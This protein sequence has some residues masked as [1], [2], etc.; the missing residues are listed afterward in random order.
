MDEVEVRVERAV[1]ED[2]DEEEEEK[3]IMIKR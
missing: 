1:V 2:A 3:C